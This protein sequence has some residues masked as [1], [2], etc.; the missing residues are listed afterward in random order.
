MTELKHLSDEWADEFDVE[1]PEMWGFLAG[2]E[3]RG[4][5][6]AQAH[7]AAMQEYGDG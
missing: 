5:T 2:C 7:T 3:L 6:K 1:E 4:W